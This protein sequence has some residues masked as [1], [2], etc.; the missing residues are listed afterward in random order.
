MRLMATRKRIGFISLAVRYVLLVAQSP[1]GCFPL[2]GDG[3]VISVA[4][5]SQC[6][7][8]TASRGASPFP[9]TRLGTGV[10]HN[11]PSL[12]L[13]S[14]PPPIPM[15]VG[16]RFVYTVGGT[17]SVSIRYLMMSGIMHTTT[18]NT[19]NIVPINQRLSNDSSGCWLGKCDIIS[20]ISWR[21]IC[22]SPARLLRSSL[23]TRAP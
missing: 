11:G 20:S 4:R 12:R 8:A 6:G 21:F 16:P 10:A 22:F 13:S 18:K 3:W 23:P 2:A 7:V 19:I 5:P 14:H 9:P 15:R 17:E 1:A